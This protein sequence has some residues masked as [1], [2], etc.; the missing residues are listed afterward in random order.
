MAASIGSMSSADLFF[1]LWPGLG[2]GLSEGGTE[3]VPQAGRGD[4]AA[5]A[6]AAGVGGGESLHVSPMSSSS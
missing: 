4:D 2:K 6:A 1:F 3:E 5:A